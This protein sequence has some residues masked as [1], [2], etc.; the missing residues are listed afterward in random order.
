[1]RDIISRLEANG[2]YQVRTSG[3][4]RHYKHSTKPGLVTVAGHPDQ[5]LPPKTVA[6]IFKQAQLP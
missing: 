4:H 2:W 3:S 6:S 5:D 1:M